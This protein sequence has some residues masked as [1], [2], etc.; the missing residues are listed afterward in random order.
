MLIARALFD[1]HDHTVSR[2]SRERTKGLRNSIWKIG[3]GDKEIPAW[4][5]S[6]GKSL[7]EKRQKGKQL[8]CESLAG[9]SI[10]FIDFNFSRDQ[11]GLL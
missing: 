6:Y 8:F 2:N 3:G 5:E 1:L 4:S 7:R 11:T 10:T 9:L